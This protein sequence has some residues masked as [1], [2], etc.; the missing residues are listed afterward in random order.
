MKALIIGATGLT[1]GKILKEL[2]D[3]PSFTEIVS[4]QRGASVVK[5][6]KLRVVITDMRD[7]S[8]V[9]DLVKGDVLFNAMGTTIKKAGSKKEQQRVDRDIPIEFARMASES[10]VSLMLN[11]SSIG[12]SLKGGFYLRT[13]AEMEHGTSEAMGGRVIHFRPSILLGER[14]RS[15]FRLAER[16]L[17]ALMYLAAPLMRG[18]LKK[19]RGM[20]TGKLAKA[21]VVASLKP[22]N[23]QSILYYSDIVKIADE[24]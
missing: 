12:A 11:V 24:L 19:Y 13:K 21:M 9:K 7:L 1:G 22:E 23:L 10:G 14:S 8:A 2:L 20:D 5:H 4:F 3:N 6:P 15:D 16:V 18:A 17:G